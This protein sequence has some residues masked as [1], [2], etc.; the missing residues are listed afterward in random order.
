[1][2]A[3]RVL[4]SGRKGPNGMGYQPVAFDEIKNINYTQ[5]GMYEWK[6]KLTLTNGQTLYAHSKIQVN[7]TDFVR[8]SY[9]RSL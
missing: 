3:E 1:M 4:K 7:G 2:N 9:G 8:K 6:Y 5:G